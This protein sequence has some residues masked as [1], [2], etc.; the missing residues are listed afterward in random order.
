M[1]RRRHLLLGHVL[2]GMMSATRLDHSTV[3]GSASCSTGFNSWF[4]SAYLQNTAASTGC[5]SPLGRIPLVF[6][7]EASFEYFFASASK[8]APFCSWRVD[9]RR[10]RLLLLA[11][12][13]CMALAQ[14]G[15]L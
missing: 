4:V 2:P 13:I 5:W 1:D 7:D 15:C 9:Q 11:T 12:T 14:A 6:A 3:A 8:L 10:E